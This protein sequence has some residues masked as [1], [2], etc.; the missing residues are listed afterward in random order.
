LH[1]SLY[2]YSLPFNP[3]TIS[4]IFSVHSLAYLYLSATMVTR[5]ASRTP[6][7]VTRIVYTVLR[8]HFC[9]YSENFSQSGEGPPPPCLLCYGM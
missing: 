1:L 3:S 7:G 9:L 2:R 4:P 5:L 8:T 6:N